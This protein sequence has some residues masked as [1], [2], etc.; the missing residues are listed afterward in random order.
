MLGLLGAGAGRGLVGRR[1]LGR[2]GFALAAFA[3]ALRL[4]AAGAVAACAGSVGAC[5]SW[6]AAS[7]SCASG[8]P[9]GASVAGTGA[10]PWSCSSTRKS[11]GLM[12]PSSRPGSGG[13]DVV[14]G[15]AEPLGAAADR[16]QGLALV[17]GAARR[18]VERRQ[19]GG[20][21]L[22]AEVGGLVMG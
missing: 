22:L 19:D 18:V 20:E 1:G 9:C 11:A 4:A 17:G 2:L 21:L 13:E 8:A 3:L 12:R 7:P 10:L 15:E 5:G 16:A 14:G 6:A